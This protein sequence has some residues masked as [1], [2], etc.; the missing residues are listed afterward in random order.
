MIRLI[1]LPRLIL[2]FLLCLTLAA[3][4]GWEQK[5]INGRGYVSLNS[6]KA[7]Y[8]FATLTRSGKSMILEN[9]KVK[10]QLRLGDVD[11]FMNGV[12]FV[13]SYPVAESAG[14]AWV[15]KIDLT[16]LVHPVLRPQFIEKAGNFRTVIIDAGHGGKDAGATNRLG[17]E[18]RYNLKVANLLKDILEKEYKY[19]V[20]MTRSD[21]RYL[22]LQQR[23]DVANRVKENAIFISIHHNS[24]QSKAR[25]IET[26]T[27]SPV[28]VAHYG[29]GLK[30]SDFRA[31]SGNFHD[32][33]NVALATS[34]HGMLLTTLKDKKTGKPY[35]LDRGIKRAR[36]S[37]LSGVK[38]PSILV[39]CGFMSNPYEARLINDSGYQRTVAKAIA[40]AVQKYRYAVGGS[41]STR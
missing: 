4:A 7:N 36:F 13:F 37:V 39:E 2:P 3:S 23:V 28:G 1:T 6:I 30:T 14:K 19:R 41:K 34:V 40:F 10:M 32:S 35:T 18:A 17:T 25:G 5:Q 26:F 11:C 29:R 12:K 21:D 16:K 22:S 27:L 15:S 31:V 8:G 24:G 38:H 20:I 33:A 9:P